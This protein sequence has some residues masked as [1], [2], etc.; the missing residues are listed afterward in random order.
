MKSGFFP[1][2]LYLLQTDKDVLKVHRSKFCCLG[3]RQRIL[4]SNKITHSILNTV[5]LLI[6][7]TL[8]IHQ[9]NEIKLGDIFINLLKNCLNVSMVL[10]IFELHI[11]TIAWVSSLL[12]K[13]VTDKIKLQV[14]YRT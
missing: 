14:Y 4:Y 11:L 12:L 2:F 6:N 13:E 3:H 5:E 8:F 9:R 1:P 7:L 10:W